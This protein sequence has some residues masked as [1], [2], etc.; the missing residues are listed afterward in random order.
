LLILFSG[1]QTG[2]RVLYSIP[3]LGGSSGSPVFDKSG[4]LVAVNYA[5]FNTTQSFNYGI[6]AKYLKT[7]AM[8]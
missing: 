8:Q 2:I 7:L 5:G 3:S 4:K 1:N 6:L